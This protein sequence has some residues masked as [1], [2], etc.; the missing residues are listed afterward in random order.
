MKALLKTLRLT[1]LL[2]VFSAGLAG[3]APNAALALSTE[4][5]ARLREAS[6]DYARAEDN[7][8]R[9]W[10]KLEAAAAPERMEKYRPL[11]ERWL[12]SYRDYFVRSLI[13]QF[14][15]DPNSLP[16]ICL[17]ERDLVSLDALYCLVTQERA[18]MLNI[19]VAQSADENLV[20]ALA[21]KLKT[22]EHG[23]VSYYVFEPYLW[24]TTFTVCRADELDKLTPET[25]ERLEKATAEP[26]ET[27]ILHG[28]FAGPDYYEADNRLSIENL[29]EGMAWRELDVWDAFD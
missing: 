26:G 8:N 22:F 9:M 5:D 14:V 16:A 10:A 6:Q 4:T 23:G 1:V 15:R 7:M 18:K 19:L 3:W 27:V 20:V 12:E 21:G 17:D 29:P 13:G 28:R 2:A 11:Q 25:A 24:K